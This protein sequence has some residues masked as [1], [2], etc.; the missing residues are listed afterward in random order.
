M[1]ISVTKIEAISMTRTAI[2]P[3]LHRDLI[4]FG[5]DWGKLP[6]ST[7][8]LVQRLSQTRKVL[9]I[10]SIGLRQPKVC[11][12]DIR[13][14]WDKLCAKNPASV[15]QLDAKGP[16][17]FDLYNNN[18]ICF[19]NPKTFPAPRTRL[20]RWF[21]R[22]I[23]LWQLRPIVSKLALDSPILW[24]S[25]PTAVDYAGY[26]NDSD[27]VYYCGDDFRYLSGVDHSTAERREVEMLTKANLIIASS[28]NLINRFPE[29]T[30]RFLPHGVDFN[31]FSQPVARAHDLPENTNPTAGFYGSISEWIDFTLLK[32]T[33]SRLQHWNFVFIGRVHV[34]ISEISGFK[35]TYFL[36]E[37]AHSLLPTYCQHWTASLLPF[38]RNEQI[39]ACNPL[40][41]RE[42]LAAG[43]PIISTSF[44]AAM[45][46]KHSISIVS[47]SS[48]M[49]TALEQTINDGNQKA[50]Q[51][52]VTKHTWEAR[53][54]QVSKWLDEL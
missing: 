48:D 4:V 7:Q 20:A 29:Q 13:R 16:K 46:Y 14:L 25:L 24:A 27:L 21:S 54:N 35:N 19:F 17:D 39:K 51:R 36:G 45:E 52:M 8:H 34:D 23:L 6:S 43:K 2:D 10:N 53:A 37:K 5:E 49:V 32:K 15:R 12:G 47:N 9:W 3:P 50:R 42:Y 44:P 40:K 41:L 22:C 26:L 18:N 30:T 1:T 28:E 33:I 38:I 11:L 31:L